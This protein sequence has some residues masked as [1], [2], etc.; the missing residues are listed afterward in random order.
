MEIRMPL[1]IYKIIR[2]WILAL[3]SVGGE[4]PLQKMMKY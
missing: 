2:H 3:D 4:C 1:R